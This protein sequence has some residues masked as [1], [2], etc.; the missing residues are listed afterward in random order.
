[1]SNDPEEQAWFREQLSAIVEYFQREGIQPPTN[2]EVGFSLPPKLALWSE[3]FPAYSRQI[4]VISGDCPTDYL[5]FDTE[6][7]SRQAMARFAAH[8][9]DVAAVMQRGQQ[10]PKTRIGDPT[11]PEELKE[12]GVMLEQR[13][14]TLHSFAQRDD[15]W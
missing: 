15:L 6:L 7:N 1:V 14:R 10:H 13:A 12:L 3:S 5:V 9:M 4:W 2:L 8:W 11:K